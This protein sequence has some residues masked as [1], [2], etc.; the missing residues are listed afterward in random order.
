[1][2]TR[3]SFFGAVA[4][5]VVGS[6]VAPAAAMSERLTFGGHPLIWDEE[7][8]PTWDRRA[9]KGEFVFRCRR[10]DGDTILELR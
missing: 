3:R 7:L 2:I 4:A 6:R 1:M 8:P 9:V 5:L 10:D